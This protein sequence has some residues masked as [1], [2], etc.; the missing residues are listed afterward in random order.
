MN[1]Y[2]LPT[3][4][5][6]PTDPQLIRYQSSQGIDVFGVSVCRCALPLQMEFVRKCMLIVLCQLLTTLAL[7]MGLQHIQLTWHWLQISV[8]TW[9]IPLIPC[10]VACILILWQL[11]VFY[12]QLVQLARIILLILFSLLS[13]FIVSETGTEKF[14]K[15]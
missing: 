14:K 13:A 7:T 2:T 8:L 3:H 15:K 5:P 12:F 1:E 6:Y 4:N 10:V 11:W 9:W